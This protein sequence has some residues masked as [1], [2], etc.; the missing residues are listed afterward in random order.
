MTA[1]EILAHLAPPIELLEHLERYEAKGQL[2][3]CIVDWL[4]RWQGIRSDGAT[5]I[6]GATPAAWAEMGILIQ[7]EKVIA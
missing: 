7:R 4:H 6:D 1:H 5:P 3:A 2:P